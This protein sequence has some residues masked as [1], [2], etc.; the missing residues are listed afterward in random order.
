[1]PMM[2]KISVSPL[3]TRNSSSPYWTPFSSWIEEER[4]Q[5]H[6]RAQRDQQAGARSAALRSR[7]PDLARA[8]TVRRR[9]SRQLAAARP[10]RR[11]P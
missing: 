6:R 4:V 1:M 8:A 10:D 7:R 2:P 11:A 5:I 3:A 9:P